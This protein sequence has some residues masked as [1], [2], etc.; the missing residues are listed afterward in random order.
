MYTS[1]KQGMKEDSVMY[2]NTELSFIPCSYDGYVGI[3]YT[4][5]CI[6][7]TFSNCQ[8]HPLCHVFFKHYI[9]TRNVFLI[10]HIT[11]KAG[12]DF[13][14]LVDPKMQSVKAAGS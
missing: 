7:V 4:I 10:A 9:I 6:A 3:F 14:L 12:W 2:T 13:S 5:F 11:P 1:H 8:S